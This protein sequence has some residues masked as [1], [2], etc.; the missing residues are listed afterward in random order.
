MLPG[1]KPRP[2]LD[3]HGLAR[4]EV[5]SGGIQE[6]M[7]NLPEGYRPEDRTVQPP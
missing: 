4:S 6:N 1:M 3:Y 7:I 2:L 5:L